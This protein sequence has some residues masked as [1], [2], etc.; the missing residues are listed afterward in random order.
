V[1]PCTASRSLATV[2]KS[3]NHYF[4]PLKILRS[5]P[6]L[7][8]PLD[9]PD[10]DRLSHETCQIIRLLHTMPRGAEVSNV[11]R[12]FVLDALLQGIRVDGRQ[13]NDSRK[14]ELEFGDD[15]GCVTVQLGLTR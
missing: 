11:E 12:Q 8:W 3:V 7:K 4:E 9:K 13:L 6:T 14:L 2:V 10:V 1:Q 15:A 5:F